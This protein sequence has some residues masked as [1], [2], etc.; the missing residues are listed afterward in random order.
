[1]SEFKRINPLSDKITVLG[2]H[3][4][5]YY[6]GDATT[7]YKHFMLGLGI[8]LASKSDFSTGNH[9]HASY[10]LQSGNMRMLFTAPYRTAHAEETKS[11]DSPVLPGFK[12]DFAAEFF[13][14]HG[15]GVRAVAIEVDDVTKS[16][17]TMIENGAGHV[18]SPTRLQDDAGRGYFDVAEVKL[19]GDVVIRI[20]N[21][22]NFS[23][24]FL[25]NFKDLVD[26]KSKSVGRYGLERFDHIV[27]NVWKMHEMQEYVKKIT[28]FH[29]FAEF[30]AEDVGTVDSGLN[31]VVLANNN[32]SVLLPINEPT[33]GTKR[34]SQIQTYLEQNNGPG[35]QHMALFTSDIFTTLKQ[36]RAAGALGGLE[37][38]DPQPAAYY[39]K[40]PARLGPD[41][42]VT[43]EQL[44]QA[45]ELGVLVDKDDQ[46]V[47][48][49]IFT[50]PVGDRPTLFFEIIQR[51]GCEDPV[52]GIQ[53]AGCGGFGKG[54]FKDLF[55]SIEDYENTLKIN[56]L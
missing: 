41:S 48:L 5:E 24:N 1:M 55:K 19:Y 32:E 37:F 9:V 10:L 27:G 46:G 53:K 33:Y 16:Y 4:V 25:P 28:G 30:T 49:Q 29:E 6:C 31:S 44:R 3:H 51:V 7:C 17:N 45:Q 54:N 21:G 56:D 11:N 8:E 38:M 34:K 39:E 20:V 40:L 35:V 15:F 2:F 36:M 47:L 43:G 18:L 13:R 50:K 42:G 22:S 14:N 52:T 23:G 26:L 12:Q